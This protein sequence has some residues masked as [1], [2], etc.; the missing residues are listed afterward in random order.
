VPLPRTLAGFRREGVERVQF[1]TPEVHLEV[2]T[3]RRS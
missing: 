2:A 3:Y 1:L